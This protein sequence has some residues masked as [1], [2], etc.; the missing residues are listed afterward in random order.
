MKSIILTIDA[1]GLDEAQEFA[2]VASL[3]N[4]LVRERNSRT[5]FSEPPPRL[6]DVDVNV[7]H[8]QPTQRGWVDARFVPISRPVVHNWRDG[9]PTQE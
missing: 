8:G 7:F 4:R 9:A 2:L 6:T 1:P 5:L 3:A